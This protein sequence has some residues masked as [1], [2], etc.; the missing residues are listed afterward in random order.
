MGHAPSDHG[1]DIT[2]F[3]GFRISYRGK[4]LQHVDASSNLTDEQDR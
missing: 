3:T 2:M 1:Q 4:I